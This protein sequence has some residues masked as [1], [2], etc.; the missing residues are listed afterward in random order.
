VKVTQV[1][2]GGIADRAGVVVGDV[3]VEYG[4]E[5]GFRVSGFK[6]LV[7]DYLNARQVTLSVMNTNN[8][9]SAVQVP[10][11]TLGVA[12]EDIKK[13]PRPRRPP[14]EDRNRDRRRAR[15]QN[16]R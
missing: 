10:G 3:I 11:G 9:I 4:G 15:P 8:E 14:E 2:K 5:T 6:K 7:E 16:R 13:P 1:R 12:V